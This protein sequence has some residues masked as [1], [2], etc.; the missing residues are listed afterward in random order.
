MKFTKLDI[1]GLILIEPDIFTDTRGLFFES[2][3]MIQFQLAGI[4]LQFVQDNQSCSKKDVIRGLHFQEV[5]S[6][7]GKLVSVIKGKVL[8]VAVDIRRN[9]ETF[10]HHVTVELNDLNKHMLWIPP[11]FAHGFSVFEDDTVF[12]YKCTGFYNKSSENGIRYDDPTLN[13]NWGVAHP[14]VSEKDMS[15]KSFEEYKFQSA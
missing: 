6:E 12:Y 14:I 11:G 2:Y 13:I 9:S 7:Q 3:N 4:N 15:L 8:D 5:P 10:G 1:N